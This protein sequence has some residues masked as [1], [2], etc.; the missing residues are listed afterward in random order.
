MP[1]DINNF[2]TGKTTD[3][4]AEV[5][6]K[7]LQTNRDKAYLATE[8]FEVMKGRKLE[9]S[10]DLFEIQNVL[11]TLTRDRSIVNRHVETKDGFQAYYSIN[12]D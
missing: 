6:K 2:K 7:F 8:L 12:E 4:M 11:Y 3:S 9:S 1:I 5:V 10:A